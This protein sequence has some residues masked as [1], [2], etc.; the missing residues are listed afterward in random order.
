MKTTLMIPDAL[1]GRIKQR[2]AASGRTISD[3]VTELLQAGLRASNERARTLPPLPTSDMGE[4][5]VD[6]ADRDA[7]YRAM[8]E[9]EPDVS[10]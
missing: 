5:K 3:S 4:A 9:W 8:E 6:I 7:L 2:A 1:Y 10:D